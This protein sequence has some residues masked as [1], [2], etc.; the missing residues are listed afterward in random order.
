[1]LAGSPRT[2]RSSCL[3]GCCLGLL[4]LIQA[5]AAPRALLA[6]DDVAAPDAKAARPTELP[7]E[8]KPELFYLLDKSGKLLPV[9][10]F[11]FEDFIKLHRLQKRLDQ[12]EQQPHY[13]I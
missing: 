3:A 5:W 2:A 12:Q 1:M 11:T 4:A 6:Q 7:G 8:V 9:P 10:G 13:S